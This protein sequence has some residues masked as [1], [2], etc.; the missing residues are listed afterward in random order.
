MDMLLEDIICSGL[1]SRKD[2]RME[3]AEWN[4]RYFHDIIN[5]TSNREVIYKAFFDKIKSKEDCDIREDVYYRLDF[6]TNF[7]PCPFERRKI[8]K[9]AIPAINFKSKQLITTRPSIIKLQRIFREHY[10]RPGGKGFNQAELEF[11]SNC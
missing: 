11:K 10:Y 1:I 2:A 4:G 7:L 9:Y 8:I 5:P 3:I 6:C